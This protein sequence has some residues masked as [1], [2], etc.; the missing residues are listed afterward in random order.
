MG[1]LLWDLPRPELQIYIVS[2]ERNTLRLLTESRLR[3]A[4]SSATIAQV[5]PSPETC[6]GE[7][8]F[9]GR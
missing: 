5:F 6:V 1:L 7:L 4:S 8:F 2:S 3:T 9:R